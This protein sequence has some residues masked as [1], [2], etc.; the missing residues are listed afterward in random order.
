MHS[1]TTICSQRKL[2]TQP[3]IQ[4]RNGA[5]TLT[6]LSHNRNWLDVSVNND[7]VMIGRSA[8]DY[9]YILYIDVSSIYI[10]LQTRGV[11][12]LS[13]IPVLLLYRQQLLPKNVNVIKHC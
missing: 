2:I 9:R 11:Y 13:R 8:F 10:I 4:H 3:E 12:E 6:Q 1:T 5:N 7:H